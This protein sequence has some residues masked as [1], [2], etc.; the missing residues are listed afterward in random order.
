MPKLYYASPRDLP[1]ITPSAGAALGLRVFEE[2]T[3][4]IDVYS[5]PRTDLFPKA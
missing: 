4:V 1:M 2:P 3:Q 5:P